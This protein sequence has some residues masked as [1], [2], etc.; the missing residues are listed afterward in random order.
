LNGDTVFLTFYPLSNPSDLHHS[1]K[2]TTAARK[3][4]ISKV[5][6]SAKIQ[7]TKPINFVEIIYVLSVGTEN[8]IAFAIHAKCGLKV[9]TLAINFKRFVNFVKSL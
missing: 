2:Q 3:S 1:F 4:I 5:G 9:P 8:T 6:Y 7:T